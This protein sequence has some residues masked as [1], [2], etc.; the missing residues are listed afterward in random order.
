VFWQV[1][2]DSYLYNGKEMQDE[3]GL[4]WYDYGARMYDPEIG[5]WNGVDALAEKYLDWSLYNYTLGNPIRFI[6]PDGNYVTWRD[7]NGNDL[8]EEQRKNVKVYIFYDSTPNGEDGGFPDQT[9]RQYDDYVKKYGEGSVALSDAR[10]EEEFAKDWGD[11]EGTPNTIVMNLH[12][13]NQALHLDTDPDGNTDTKDGQY[14]VSTDDG[15]TNKSGT[16]GTKISDLPTPNADISTTTLCLNTCNSNNPSS[17]KMTP[18]T[19]LAVGFSKDTK[20]GTV[21][22]SNKKINFNS[23]GQ[24]KTQWYYGGSWQYFRGGQRVA[25]P[26]KPIYSYG[27]LKVGGL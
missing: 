20:V 12:G 7:K 3:L 22:G 5:R 24:P 17:T 21:R 2:V 15:K 1:R 25:S 14:I 13:T 16:P 26:Y 23:K 8:S 27:Q 9:M 10:T 19:T 4:N 11:M 18:G 6:D